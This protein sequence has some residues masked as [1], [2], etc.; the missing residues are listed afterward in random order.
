MP[1]TIQV[2]GRGYHLKTFFKHDFFAATA[3]YEGPPGRVILKIQR[4]APFFGIPL[5]WIGRLLANHE[6]AALDRLRGLE[7]VPQVL[8]RWGPTGFVREYIDGH[9]LGRNEWVSDDFHPRLRALVDT[10]HQRDMAYVDL[11]K[12]SNVVVGDDGRPYLIDFQIA[13]I[14]PRRYGGDLWPARL[15]RRWFQQGDRY[16]LTKLQRRSRPDQLT[17]EQLEA[18]YRKPW[19]VRAF[20]VVARPF[21][22]C[23]RGLLDRLAGPRGRGE[24]GRLP[25]PP[26]QLPSLPPATVK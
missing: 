12:A 25:D 10:M 23:R 22:W 3:M 16:H 20:C 11:N 26:D 4:P 7:G 19:H 21:L 14:L 9:P 2:G 24:R 15:L 18:S 6:I 5:S 1:P 13:W 8:Q 17:T